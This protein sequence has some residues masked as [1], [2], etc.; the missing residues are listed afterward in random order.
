MSADLENALVRRMATASAL[1]ARAVAEVRSDTRGYIEAGSHL[2]PDLFGNLTI[3]RDSEA[4]L[5]IEGE[6]GR[7]ELIREIEGFL[8]FAPAP[9]PDWFDAIIAQ[10][11]AW[12]EVSPCAN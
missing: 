3:V 1:L 12:A 8:G 9:G 6:M 4:R 7:I 10:G 2:V 11:P 5:S